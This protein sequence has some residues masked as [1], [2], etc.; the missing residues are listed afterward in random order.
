VARTGTAHMGRYWQ[1]LRAGWRR[2]AAYRAATF[3]GVFT[4]TVFGFLRA[5]VL[6]AT[7]E[8]AG[9]IGGY[10][11]ADALTYTWLTQGLIMVIAIWRWNDLATRIQSGDIATDLSRPIDLQGA[12]L[13]ED[14]GRAAYQGVFRGLPPFLV[15]ALFFTLRLPHHPVTWFA[16]ALSIVLAVV[17]SFGMRFIVNLG[18]FWLLDWRGTSALAGLLVTVLSG[19]AIPLNFYPHWARTITEL[20]PWG[21]MVQL[22]INIFLE[23][24]NGASVVGLLLLQ[25]AWAI[26]L[27]L[28]G[29]RLLAAGT[30]KLVVQ[31]G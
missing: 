7:L 3:A 21:S 12:W 25:A 20:L 17:V 2:S 16:F 27:L 14:L 5:A 30:R 13:A 4:N 1:L 6:I 19:F 11:R 28:I 15:G 22:P 31:G 23:Q 24:S 8:V 9:K 26:A 29:R 10:D 18:A